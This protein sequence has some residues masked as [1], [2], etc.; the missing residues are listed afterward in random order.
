MFGN[1]SFKS[2]FFLSD[3]E[4]FITEKR[5][6]FGCEK[7]ILRHFPFMVPKAFGLQGFFTLLILIKLKNKS[8]SMT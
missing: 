1:N 7:V 2:N 6:F 5:W 3:L 4:S 8:T